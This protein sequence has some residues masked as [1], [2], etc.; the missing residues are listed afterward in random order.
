[1]IPTLGKLKQEDLLKFEATLSY[2]VQGQFGQWCK[3]V[4]KKQNKTTSKKIQFLVKL[5]L[6]LNGNFI[7]CF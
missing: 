3:T 4:S 1:V 6:S 7:G 5:D 2:I